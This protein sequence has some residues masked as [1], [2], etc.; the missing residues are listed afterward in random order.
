MS[1]LGPPALL[2]GAGR[3][4]LIAGAAGGIGRATVAL[5]RRAGVAVAGF[6]RVSAGTDFDILGDASR[7]ADLAAAVETTL[8]RFGRIDH[9][10]A[11]VGATGAGTLDETSADEWHRLL[12]INLTASALLARA[13]H[14]AL[15][16][17]AGSL[18]LASST[19]G[20]NGGSSLSGPAYAVAKG[21]ILTLTRYLAKEW[22]TDRVRVNCI[23]PG[24]VATPMLHRL[25]PATLDALRGAI[26]LGRFAEPREIAAVL[27][28]LCSDHAA[29]ITG[30]CINVSGGLVLD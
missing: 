10:I 15:K 12:E 13:A 2:D 25:A 20:R 17:T 16:A 19:N 5:F 23:A 24:P 1:D 11:L 26:P 22:A 30:A 4:A 27:A 3:V 28:F 21:G 9:A 14:R 18:V 29:S 7:E 8:S 6:D